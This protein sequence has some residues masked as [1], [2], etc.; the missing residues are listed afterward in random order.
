[1][2]R[3]HSR[4]K[5]VPIQSGTARYRTYRRWQRWF[6]NIKD[7][8]FTLHHNR[9]IYRDVMAM[10][11][12][13]PALQVPS[14]FYTWMRT[15]YVYDM[16]MAVRRLVDRHQRTISFYRLMEEIA[17]HPEVITRRRFT[18]GYRGWLRDV[19]HR[20]FERFAS[21]TAKRIHRRVIRRHQRE[22]VAVAKRLKTYVDKHVAHNDRHPMRRL[23]RYEEL[24]QCIDLLGQLAK[25][26]T[27]LLEQ[28]GLVEVVPVIQY[29]WQAPF[30]VPWI[31]P[32]PAAAEVGD[33][34][35]TVPVPVMR[36]RGERPAIIEQVLSDERWLKDPDGTAREE[37]IKAIAELEARRRS[38]VT[39]DPDQ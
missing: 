6:D 37:A 8:I 23:P 2:A 36:R 3:K 13:N 30:R 11:D 10:I 12:E 31:P 7:Q 15:T 21:P 4:P 18:A 17:S 22:L 34:L 38:P 20:D 19:G 1:M 27:L 35:R 26:Y 28:A 5:P 32:P 25:D 39:P 14:A 9:R 29:D 16:T 33:G 24:D